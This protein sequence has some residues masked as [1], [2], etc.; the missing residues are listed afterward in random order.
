MTP[1]TSPGWRKQLE[2][3][4][5]QKIPNVVWKRV[6]ERG[7]IDTANEEEDIKDGEGLKYLVEV[8]DPLL[9]DYEVFSSSPKLPAPKKRGKHLPSVEI[10]PNKRFEAL[11]DIIATLGNR[12]EGVRKF[13]DEV[14]RGKLLSP[15]EVPEWIKAQKVKESHTLM[16][17]MDVVA[18][19]G[20]ETRVSERA[21][22]LL[23]A[24]EKGENWL[25]YVD[26][27]SGYTLHYIVPGKQ[28]VGA[29]PINK[30]GILGQ[31]KRLAESFKDFWPEAWAV[32]FILTG[33]ARPVNRGTITFRQTSRA[34]KIILELSPYLT[35]KEVRE[36]YFKERKALL[37]MA[38]GKTKVREL[39]DKHIDLAVFGVKESGSWTKKMQKWNER[40]PECKYTSKGTFARD[41]RTA[42][43]RITGW[44]WETHQNQNRKANT[45]ENG[46][47]QITEFSHERR[48]SLDKN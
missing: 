33:E 1:K 38:T 22:Q 6:I 14:L 41:V 7:Y 24:I 37:E 23:E 20:L 28:Y 19:D 48:K 3:E 15:E 32:N 35:G 11:T 39:T 29:I 45:K 13:R 26:G 25:L 4:L 47:P 36:L 18:G 44:K 8:I 31:L 9:E 42:Y 12:D 16:I 21:K 27:T 10:K 34:L 5:G 43:E 17:S 2:K 46:L 30:D 40:H